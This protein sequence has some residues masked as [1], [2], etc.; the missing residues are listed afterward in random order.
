MKISIRHW[1]WKKLTGPNQVSRVFNYATATYTST[2]TNTSVISWFS[3][4]SFHESP[5]KNFMVSNWKITVD[6]DLFHLQYNHRMKSLREL[7]TTK[8]IG[9]STAASTSKCGV[10]FRYLKKAHER[11]PT[12]WHRLFLVS[13][14]GIYKKQTIIKIANHFISC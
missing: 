11:N 1:I 2:L 7:I 6:S 5:Q 13:I 3:Y 14:L 10:T 9:Q 12:N 8:V 4:L